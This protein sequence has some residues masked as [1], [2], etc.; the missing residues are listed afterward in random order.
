M[1]HE[2]ELELARQRLREPQLLVRALTELEV[3]AGDDQDGS[4]DGYGV[5]WDV[6]D[7]YGTSF[8]P[9]TFGRG[10]LDQQL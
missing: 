9:G 5:V 4:F 1:E 8:A 7:S 3:R 10:G 2:N 6:I